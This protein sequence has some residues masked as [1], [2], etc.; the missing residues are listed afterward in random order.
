MGAAVRGLSF[1]LPSPLTE[2]RDERLDRHGVRV[3]LKRDDLVHAEVPG[4]KWRKLKYNLAEASERRHTRLLTFGG[5]FSNHIRATAAAGHY[6][7]FET[8]GVI[9]G[10]E[11]SP[12]N[13]SL[14]YARSRGMTLTYLD[15]ATYRHKTEPAVLAALTGEFG[16]CHVLPEGGGNG[17]GVR[18]CAELPGE[19]GVDFDVICCATGS[20]CTVAGIAAGLAGHQRALGFVVLKGAGYLDTEVRR[21]QRAGFGERTG[22]WALDHDFHFGGYAKRTP[23]LDRFIADFA[24]RHGITLDWVYEAKMLYGL[25]ARIASGRFE[26]GSAIVAVL[27]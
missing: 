26:R 16:P 18:G 23:E 22:D 14:A 15:R 27:S 2:L 5:A 8:V 1:G 20:G 24:F 25:Y 10:E 9:R 4:N 3:H 7:G 13:A 6:L 21:L 12:L 19:I 11:H 17:A